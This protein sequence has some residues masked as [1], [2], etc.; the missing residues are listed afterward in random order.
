MAEKRQQ[1]DE[2]VVVSL[3]ARVPGQGLVDVGHAG[4]GQEKD[5]ARRRR[6]SHEQGPTVREHDRPVGD[7]IDGS[8][9][10]PH[11]PALAGREG[12]AGELASELA[13]S[14]GEVDHRV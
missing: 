4:A 5:V 10:R 3:D 13:P 7:D 8:V 14:V 2:L 11:R 1:R 9:E 12:Q 6:Q